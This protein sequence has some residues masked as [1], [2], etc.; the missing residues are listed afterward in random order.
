MPARKRSKLE[1]EED[2]VRIAQMHAKGKLQREIAAAVNLTQ[3]QISHDLKEVYR[4]WEESNRGKLK[5]LKAKMLAKIE[6]HE[7][8]CEEAWEQSKKTKETTTQKQVKTPGGVV[9]A[10]DNAQLEPG[11]ER[12]EASLRTEERDGNPA[13]LKSIEW[14][15]EKEIELHGL[16]SPQQLEI[17]AIKPIQFIHIHE[18]TRNDP[19][20][21]YD[22]NTRAIVPRLEPP[23]P[24]TA[25]A[26]GAPP[27][28]SGN[29]A[30]IVVARPS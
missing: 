10:G 23:R 26:A 12:Q 27:S 5:I 16:D 25:H 17:D 28:G 30:K 1:R 24:E 4:R 11:S 9:G 29:G 19:P 15:M 8:R 21:G 3:Q 14:C 2:L 20:P 7:M 22:A 6:F 18:V 13:F